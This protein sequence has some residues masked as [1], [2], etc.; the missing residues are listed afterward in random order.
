MLFIEKQS[1]MIA[2]NFDNLPIFYQWLYL[3]KII[4]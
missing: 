4:Y 3:L 1:I 2:D